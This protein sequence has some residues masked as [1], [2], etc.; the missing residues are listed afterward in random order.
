MFVC[1]EVEKNSKSF[2]EQINNSVAFKAIDTNAAFYEGRK[3]DGSEDKFY[4][5]RRGL[6]AASGTYPRWYAK[7][8]S[9][10]FFGGSFAPLPFGTSKTITEFAAWCGVEIAQNFTNTDPL[11]WA[12]RSFAELV[13]DYFFTAFTPDGIS[14]V[15]PRGTGTN[16]GQLKEA[17]CLI[18]VISEKT[19]NFEG[20]TTGDILIAATGNIQPAS[21][22][23]AYKQMAVN[24]ATAAANYIIFT[25]QYAYSC[26]DYVRSWD[27]VKYVVVSGAKDSETGL[28]RY[29]GVKEILTSGSFVEADASPVVPAMAVPGEL[30]ADSLGGIAA[31]DYL[32]KTAIFED[33]R[34]SGTSVSSNENGGTPVG[35]WRVRTLNTT[36]L[37]ELSA[38]LSSNRITLPAGKYLIRWSCPG[39]QVTQWQ[40]KLYNYSDSADIQLGSCEYSRAASLGSQT[41][42]VGECVVTFASSKA[43]QLMA[44]AVTAN[45]TDGWG[46]A[47]SFGTEHYSIITIIKLP[48]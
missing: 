37:N 39:H 38:T 10:K 12:A 30:D 27:G 21:I 28:Y 17:D 40:T 20:E 14:L 4:L 18:R 29:T 31:A 36:T 6:D 44:R 13:S 25:A 43:I 45:T 7:P 47:A 15:I 34:S 42:S 46:V 32:L 11:Y 1:P 22:T 35:T 8:D 9:L 23:D 26:G 19:F 16:R 24:K 3:I 33:T 41:R 5:A 2:I 48:A